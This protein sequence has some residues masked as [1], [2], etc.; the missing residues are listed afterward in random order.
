DLIVTGVQ[1]CA[2][3]ISMPESFWIAV[4][5]IGAFAVLAGGFFAV[6]ADDFQGRLRRFAGVLHHSNFGSRG[7]G[8]VVDLGESLQL[9]EP[10][11]RS[12]ERRVGKE[13]RGGW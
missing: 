10:A 3:P 13:C 12:E 8:L 2:L 11:L 6:H 5:C 1:T 9:D 7:P 4:N